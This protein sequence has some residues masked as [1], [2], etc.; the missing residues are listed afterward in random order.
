MQF[1]ELFDNLAWPVIAADLDT[2]QIVYANPIAKNTM[3]TNAKDI[4]ALFVGMERTDVDATVAKLKKYGYLRHHII[5]SDEEITRYLRINGNVVKR[6][7]KSLFYLVLEDVTSTQRTDNVAEQY[8]YMLDFMDKVFASICTNENTNEAIGEMLSSI[9]FLVGAS[10]VYVYECAPPLA[11]VRTTYEWA[12][13]GVQPLRREFSVINMNIYPKFQ[14]A[15]EDSGMLLLPDVTAVPTRFCEELQKNGV[16]SFICFVLRQNDQMRGFIGFDFCDRFKSWSYHDIQLKGTF[17]NLVALMLG[18]RQ[19]ENQARN[20]MGILHTVLDS[21][22][23]L[24]Y[25]TDLETD[26]V[27][28]ANRRVRDLLAGDPHGRVCWQEAGSSSDSPCVGCAKGDLI[29]NDVALQPVLSERRNLADKRWYYVSDS[30]VRWTDGRFVHL[31]SAVEITDRKRHEERLQY[32]AHTDVMTETLNRERGLQVLR[33]EIDRMRQSDGRLSV[34]YVDVDGLKYVNDTWGHTEGDRLLVA[35]SGVLRET[36]RNT[37]MV[38]RMG[39]DEFLLIL[40]GCD[41]ENAQSIMDKVES[42]LEEINASNENSFLCSVSYGIKEIDSSYDGGLEDLI[43]EADRMM[44]HNKQ[45]KPQN[46]R[47]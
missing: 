18:R 3:L 30:A 8:R 7:G 38:C 16:K 44:Y 1:P 40:P 33:S 34:S 32:F 5:R 45:A 39:G 21:L 13:K 37:D 14:E 4:Y 23:V 35:I 47:R 2:L 12:A 20:N 26:E 28:F 25:V 43:D 6:E 27:L 17:A 29:A 24:V 41:K 10:R 42:R 31:Q 19:A 46:M 9:G 15:L 36:V 22:N 11:V